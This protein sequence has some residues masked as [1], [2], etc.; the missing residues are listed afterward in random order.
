MY[1]LLVSL[2]L[3]LLLA[4]AAVRTRT[5]KSRIYTYFESSESLATGCWLAAGWLSFHTVDF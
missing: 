2:L 4:T 5:R 3:S 1:V